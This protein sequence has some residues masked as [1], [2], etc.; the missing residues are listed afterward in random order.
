MTFTGDRPPK[1]NE[2]LK[3]GLV[4]EANERPRVNLSELESSVHTI[5]AAQTLHQAAEE[6]AV[7]S[8]EARYTCAK[9]LSGHGRNLTLMRIPFPLRSM[10]LVALRGAGVDS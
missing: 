7:W 6:H 2:C 1:V 5:P 8:L 9:V 10:V 3:R 4:L